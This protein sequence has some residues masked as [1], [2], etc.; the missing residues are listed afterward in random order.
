[1]LVVSSFDAL[2]EA[3]HPWLAGDMPPMSWS[4]RR[5]D[6]DGAE[7][8]R[9]PPAGETSLTF[10]VDLDAEHETRLREFIDAV[11]QR[12]RDERWRDAIEAR[13]QRS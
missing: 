11:E 10:T 2:P 9:W 8:Y 5:D 1:V 3:P 13:D 6:P 4:F 12:E 7:W